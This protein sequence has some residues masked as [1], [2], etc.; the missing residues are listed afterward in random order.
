MHPH[1]VRTYTY[2]VSEGAPL[3]CGGRRQREV[4]IV[5]VRGSGGCWYC[6]M[7]LRHAAVVLLL[8]C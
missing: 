6:G 2:G 8:C 1:I 5:Q 4:W 3:A 7:L